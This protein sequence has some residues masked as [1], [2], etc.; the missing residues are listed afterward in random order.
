MATVLPILRLSTSRSVARS[1]PFLKSIVSRMSSTER[2]KKNFS[3]TSC[4]PWLMP[5]KSR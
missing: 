1:M 3:L 2:Q 5:M 4:R